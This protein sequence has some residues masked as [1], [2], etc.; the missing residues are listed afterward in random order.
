MLKRVLI[1]LLIISIVS[2]I[3]LYILDVKLTLIFLSSFVIVAVISEFVVWKKARKT[4]AKDLIDI[5]LD[6]F[7]KTSEEK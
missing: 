5:I 1:I 4:G 7:K 2:I 3:L 6:K